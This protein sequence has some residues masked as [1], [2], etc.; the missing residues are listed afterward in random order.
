[1]NSNYQHFRIDESLTDR[2]TIWI[3]VKEKSANVLYEPVFDELLRI[4]EAA[5]ERQ[6]KLPL[7][8]RSA[9]VHSFVVG[10]DL[11]RLLSLSTDAQVQQFLWHGQV[12]FNRLEQFNGG[13]VAVIQ[14]ACL[15]GGLE[16]ALACKFRFAVDV[17][18]TQLGMPEAKLGLIPGWGGT[19]RLIQVVGVTE[20]VFML[21]AGEAVNAE[22][23]LSMHLVDALAE[24][25]RLEEKLTS[26]LGQ[27]NREALAAGSAHPVNCQALA[28][29][30]A[31]AVKLNSADVLAKAE[32]VLD[33]FGALTPAQ[34]AIYRAAV[35]GISHSLEAGLRAER[36]LFH[37]LLISRTT[38][39]NLERFI[40]RTKPKLSTGES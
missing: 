17:P 14:G 1:M 9:K 38:Q 6:S 11:R 13:S 36:E 32:R 40:N 8:F 25:S 23:A 39:A 35:L 12:V 21:L 2:V 24:Q 37:A 20:G 26:F 7:V 22:R 27:I 30:G 16:W 28:A 15:G 3:D 18:S 19:Q 10:A 31:G 33:G 5:S 34:S 29:G 4:I